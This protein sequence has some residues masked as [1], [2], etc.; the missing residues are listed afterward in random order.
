MCLEVKRKR[1]FGKGH[2]RGLN[3]CLAFKTQSGLLF[4]ASLPA[5]MTTKVQ[6]FNDCTYLQFQIRPHKVNCLLLVL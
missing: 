4:L 3:Q 5:M 1:S 2:E 6:L